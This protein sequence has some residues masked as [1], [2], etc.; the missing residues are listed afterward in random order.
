MSQI[1]IIFSDIDGTLLN[2]KKEITPATAEAI[3][4]LVAR[5]I[6]F[7]PVSARPPAGIYPIT[8]KMLGLSLPIICYGGAYVLSETGAVL[9]DDTIPH[10][11]ARRL[12]AE[13]NAGYAQKASINFYAGA[14]W[15]VTDEDGPRVRKEEA[16]TGARA[17]VVPDLMALLDQRIFPHK[18]LLMGEPDF[19]AASETRLDADFPMLHVV[20]SAPALLEITDKN[21]SK[22]SGIAA[23]LD[24]YHLTAEDAL[25]F[26][27]NY[28]DLEMLRY[29]GDSVAMA[30]APEE[31]KQAARHVTASCDEDG[32]A[33]YLKAVQ[34]ID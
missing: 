4:T 15:Y 22:A 2:K 20:R 33:V 26:G 21:V 11:E 25:A 34:L 28:N 13:L 9:A 23:L 12:L 19:I 14:H 24:F 7:V 30:N 1:K 3:R 17:E 10:E 6:P 29:T 31:V 16:I 18:I 5:G 32:I 8:T 27:D